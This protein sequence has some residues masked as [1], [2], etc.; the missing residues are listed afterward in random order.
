MAVKRS[1]RMG[2]VLML[3]Q[4]AEDE[5]ARRLGQMQTQILQAQEQLQ[6][7]ESYNETYKQ[8]MMAKTQGLKVHE[9]VSSREFLQ[10]LGNA[11]LEQQQ[12]ISQMDEL[13]K[14][15]R[16]QWQQKYH[17]RRSIYELIERIKLN[18]N[19]ALEKQLQTQLD[20]M[21]TQ[22]FLRRAS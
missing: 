20:E 6:Q 8:E 15:L 3:A 9:I 4:R 21:A 11:A 2:V 10:R 22:L 13:L 14:A 19:D 5:A 1:K 7:I 17:Y 18:E 16:E 12:R